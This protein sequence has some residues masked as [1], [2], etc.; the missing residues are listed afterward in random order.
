MEERILVK[1]AQMGDRE[2]F[3]KLYGLY[4]DR[5]Y[6]YAFYR[7]QHA[8]DAEDAVSEC[9]LALWK[10]L[11]G[12]REPD[13]FPVWSYRILSACCAK[14]IRSQINRRQETDTDGISV[15]GLE[16]LRHE[17]HTDTH[18]ILEEAL[19]RIGEKEREIVLLSAVSGLT[20][21]QIADITG[22]TPGAV[23]SSLSRSFKKLRTL[24]EG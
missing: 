7:L 18:L 8:A 21:A 13:A 16:E 12:L 14:Q 4:K 17:E 20:S 24:L 23:R 2:A 6:R 22:L 10:Q 9:V 3:C 19:S 1:Q 15:R 11:P 5:Y